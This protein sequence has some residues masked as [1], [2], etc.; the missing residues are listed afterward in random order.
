MR[1]LLFLLFSLPCQ[2][3]T[4]VLPYQVSDQPTSYD[5][6]FLNQKVTNLSNVINN[7]SASTTTISNNIWSGSNI[8]QSTL[9]IGLLAGP[10]SYLQGGWFLTQYS[11]G[12]NQTFSVIFN[13]ST[14]YQWL[15]SISVT[16]G[17]SSALQTFKCTING[18]STAAHYNQAMGS[19]SHGYGIDN[20]GTSANLSLN[21]CGGGAVNTGD[22][23]HGTFLVESV[24][25]T[26][27]VLDLTGNISE[28]CQSVAVNN[29]LFG[30]FY[31]QASGPWTLTC[32]PTSTQGWTYES[33]VLQFGS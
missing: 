7:P 9:T 21:A 12:T 32:K 29:S 13:T 26:P 10:N 14:T 1:F 24:F 22:F 19:Y 30:N 27:A 15:W 28:S 6:D 2:A 8:F 25:G 16:S 11:S 33:R 20:E 18:D 17:T 5:L 4:N 3:Q 23:S 31:F